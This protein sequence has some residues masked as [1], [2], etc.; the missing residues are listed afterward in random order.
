[1]EEL[2]HLAERSSRSP[3]RIELTSVE[4]LDRR[5][6]GY[7]LQAVLVVAA[8]YDPDELNEE[9]V[10]AQLVVSAV[11]AN[12]RQ[13]RGRAG[14]DPPR[15]R[16]QRPDLSPELIE[17][18]TIVR[19]ALGDRFL[20]SSLAVRVDRHRRPPSSLLRQV[21]EIAIEPQQ[22]LRRQPFVREQGQVLHRA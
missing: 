2:H 5:S 8:V 4:D 14:L 10:E 20:E 1:A 13:R 11:C 22:E 16:A 6:R 19:D 3:V 17:D 18:F 12:Q 9:G 7:R 15:P 21:P